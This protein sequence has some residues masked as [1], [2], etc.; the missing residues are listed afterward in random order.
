LTLPEIVRVGQRGVSV[1]C[2]P[3]E[4]PR[5]VKIC[6]SD[7]HADDMRAVIG[8]A[9]ELGNALCAMEQRRF[10]I[11]NESRPCY[12]TPEMPGQVVHPDR[13]TDNMVEQVLL[14]WTS[15]QRMTRTGSLYSHAPAVA[16]LIGQPLER[17]WTHGDFDV[18]HMYWL[19]GR[20]AGVIDFD[21]AMF[22]DGRYD[23]ALFI[24]SMVRH[25]PPKEAIG[26]AR[27]LARQVAARSAFSYEALLAW[28][29]GVARHR[30]ET[31]PGTQNIGPGEAALTEALWTMGGVS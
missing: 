17:H 19:D 21:A 5:Y 22:S 31:I 6:D 12:V 3:G 1:I 2:L 28:V 9:H 29:A 18:L 14:L 13:I 30:F 7:R 26:R 24:Y 20:L 10:R 27:E 25:L 11:G 15:L 4:P 16:A 8:Q 23:L